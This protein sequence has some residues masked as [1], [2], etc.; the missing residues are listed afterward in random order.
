MYPNY[1]YIQYKF[2]I[3]DNRWGTERYHN[4]Q[5]ITISEFIIIT[6]DNGISLEQYQHTSKHDITKLDHFYQN[7]YLLHL[8]TG[9][10]Y[11]LSIFI[12]G[13]SVSK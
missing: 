1:H 13:E 6:T 9:H 12:S 8:H 10:L 11:L 4:K 2:K 5:Y 7:K 3:L